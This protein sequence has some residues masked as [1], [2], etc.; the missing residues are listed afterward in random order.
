MQRASRRWFV[1]FE[2]SL[3]QN[4]RAV[5]CRQ[6]TAQ[7]VNFNN[8]DTGRRSEI[9]DRSP[10]GGKFHK[11]CPDGKRRLSSGKA[12]LRL[13]VETYP[14]NS[15]QVGG[16]PNEPGI[17]LVVSGSRLA[18]SRSCKAPSSGRVRCAAVENSFQKVV[19]D[20]SYLR[21]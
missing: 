4:I 6:L 21:C 13:V 9:G 18:G 8:L 2:K 12:Q 20:E 11:F 3:T 10:G 15:Q 7:R 16:I 5:R 1:T 14:H 19:H 17:L